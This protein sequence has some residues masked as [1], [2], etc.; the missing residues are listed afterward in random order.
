MMTNKTR[1]TAEW[2]RNWKADARNSFE[3]LARLQAMGKGRVYAE[4]MQMK[5]HCPDLEKLRDWAHS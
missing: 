5:F 1:Y 3:I 2:I 4:N